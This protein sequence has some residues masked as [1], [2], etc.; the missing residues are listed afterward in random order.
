MFDLQPVQAALR[1]FQF[2][3]WLLCDFRGSNLLARPILDLADRPLMSLRIFY[4][5]PARRQAHTLVHRIEPVALDH[6]PGEKTV[7]LRW[8]ELEAGLGSMLNEIKNVAME[9]SPRNAN[10][11]V[12]RVDAGLVELV[13]TFVPSVTS[14]GDLVQLF[15]ASWDDEQW[16]MHQAA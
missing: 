16:Q 12:S 2:D 14:S 9:Y 5:V 3:A 4:L 15:E 13:R 11:Y 10:P 6:L 1:E 8:Q 7:Y